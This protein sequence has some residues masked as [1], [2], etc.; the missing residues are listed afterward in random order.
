[1]VGRTEGFV[2]DPRI[3]TGMSRCC[4]KWIKSIKEMY[5]LHSKAM[6]LGLERILEAHD[7]IRNE[8]ALRSAHPKP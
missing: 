5:F 7:C 3:E 6:P 1:V 4:E 8:K 2:L